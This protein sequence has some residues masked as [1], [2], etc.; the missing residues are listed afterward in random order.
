ML[1]YDHTLQLSTINSELCTTRTDAISEELQSPLKILKTLKNS[2]KWKIIWH[3]CLLHMHKMTKGWV[4]LSKKMTLTLIF[5]LSVIQR[6]LNLDESFWA[7]RLSS[8]T[9]PLLYLP[10]SLNGIIPH[11][12]MSQ[13]RHCVWHSCKAA[14]MD[15]DV[16]MVLMC[17]LIQ[18]LQVLL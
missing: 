2:E 8:V 15:N 5:Q 16:E 10:C 6:V 13:M 12:I 7:T 3:C 18:R 1:I 14:F 11:L 17:P 9:Q 4:L